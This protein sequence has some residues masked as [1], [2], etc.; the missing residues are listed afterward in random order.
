MQ[1]VLNFIICM[2]ANCR[3]NITSKALIQCG[4]TDASPAASLVSPVRLKKSKK[5]LK[6]DS[7]DCSAGIVTRLRAWRLMNRSSIPG[8][9][10]RF[11]SS[12]EPTPALE[13]THPPLRGYKGLLPQG[14]I[15]NG[16]QL[17]TQLHLDPRVEVSGAI[18][19]SRPNTPSSPSLEYL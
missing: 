8:S 17:T 4:E 9:G 19:T 11:I 1:R 7:R 10:M 12:P 3:Y 18:R 15:D 14:K 5:W 13:T 2:D 16:V 6:W